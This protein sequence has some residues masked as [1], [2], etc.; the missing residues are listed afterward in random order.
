MRDNRK[1]HGISRQHIERD[2]TKFIPIGAG[3]IAEELSADAGFMTEVME[4]FKKLKQEKEEREGWGNR[5]NELMNILKA[6]EGGEKKVGPWWTDVGNFDLLSLI[7][8]SCCPI[9][10]FSPFFFNVL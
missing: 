9:R 3:G 7:I 8:I 4:Q 6:N 5:I 10:R 2:I 1:I